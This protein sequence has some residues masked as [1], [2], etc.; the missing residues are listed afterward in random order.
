MFNYTSPLH[1]INGSGT[2]WANQEYMR[3]LRYN[4]WYLTEIG[5]FFHLPNMNIDD[6]ISK[7]NHKIVEIEYTEFKLW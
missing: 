7:E 5:K 1:L 6:T 4:P 2:M 3:V